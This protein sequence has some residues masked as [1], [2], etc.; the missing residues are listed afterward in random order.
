MRFPGEPSHGASQVSRRPVYELTHAEFE[1]AESEM[2]ALRREQKEL[3][4]FVGMYDDM[5]RRKERASA[6]IR[7]AYEARYGWRDQVSQEAAT[8]IEGLLADQRRIRER[9][10]N[11][12]R[13]EL[14]RDG[15][16]FPRRDFE[17]E[18]VA[19]ASIDARIK[20]LLPPA[21]RENNPLS[22]YNQAQV[23][24]ETASLRREVAELKRYF[25]VYDEKMARLEQVY[26]QMSELHDYF[27]SGRTHATE[28]QLAEE[29]RLLREYDDAAL[30]GR[31]EGERWD[32]GGNG[33]ATT[34]SI[35][36][37]LE[38]LRRSMAGK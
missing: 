25:S 9:I 1:Q 19:L 4:A 16:A 22:S 24:R 20:S 8:E 31:E 34:D 12:Y 28:E 33:A 27:E 32:G 35:S 18:E 14:D 2:H 13:E 5:E 21:L 26:A 3:E 6:A 29:K 23:D 11:V 38:A 30:Q 17:R 15:R 36:R 37:R 10:E 7:G